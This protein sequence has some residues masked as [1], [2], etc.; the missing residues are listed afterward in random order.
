MNKSYRNL[1]PGEVKA[2]WK[3]GNHSE[4]LQTKLECHFPPVDTVLTNWKCSVTARTMIMSLDGTG[5]PVLSA[6]GTSEY[7]PNG[8]RPPMYTAHRNRTQSVHPN[9]PECS[10]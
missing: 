1:C 10:P 7:A 8:N 4:S 9:Y 2:G 6:S 3:Q 5:W